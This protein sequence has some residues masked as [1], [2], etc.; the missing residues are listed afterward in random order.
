MPRN[1]RRIDGPYYD[2]LYY[3]PYR[4]RYGG[5]RDWLPQ[6]H[7][8]GAT[9]LGAAVAAPVLQQ[10][11]MLKPATW[12]EMAKGALQSVGSGMWS[13]A[14]DTAYSAGSDILHQTTSDDEMASS[15]WSEAR[16]RLHGTISSKSRKSKSRS[17]SRSKSKR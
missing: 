12:A 9:M 4:R 1:V 6:G 17:R 11:G 5:W 3:A 14:K 15:V 16:N 7:H 2:P 13:K 10:T 8:P